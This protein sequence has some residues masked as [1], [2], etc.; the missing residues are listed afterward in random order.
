MMGSRLW[1]IAR[2]EL[3]GFFGTWMGY[4]II[5][6]A[7]VI[8]GVL[9]QAY[10]ITSEPKFSADVL[11]DFFYFSSGLSMVAGIFL[12]MRLLAEEKQSGTIVLFYTSPV[13]TRE[14]IYGKFLSALV[15]S[16]VLHLASLYMPALILIHGKISVGHVLAGYLCVS[17]LGA[18]TMSLT[19][20]ASALAPNQLFAAVGGAFLTVFFLTLWL[21]ANMVSEPFKG[22]L[23]FL[24]IHNEHFG[25]F[26]NGIVPLKSVVFYVTFILL[27]LEISVRV[28]ESKRSHG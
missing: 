8:E 7:L 16:L 10:A 6:A 3:V 12:A 4:V 18:V 22:I 19:M 20:F 23:G 1:L 11:S 17:L 9:F 5:A 27:F 15:F 14:L 24:S 26:S 21:L 28:M 2:R 13:T 25:P